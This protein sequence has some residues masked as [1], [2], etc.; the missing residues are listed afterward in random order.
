MTYVSSSDASTVQLRCKPRA[1]FLN[2]ARMGNRFSFTFMPMHHTQP[3]NLMA[4]VFTCVHNKKF[5]SPECLLWI[6]GILLTRLQLIV[7]SRSRRYQGMIGLSSLP[8]NEPAHTT[9]PSLLSV[10]ACSYTLPCFRFETAFIISRKSAS[11]NRSAT[12][13]RSS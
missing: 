12:C 13:A 9:V 5:N 3:H 2:T 8:P 7:P 1:A 6:V 10:V 4:T 11:Q